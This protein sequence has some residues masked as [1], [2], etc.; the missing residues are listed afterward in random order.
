MNLKSRVVG[1]DLVSSRSY[2]ESTKRAGTRPA[3]TH[4]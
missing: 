4:R 3:P 1:E 2:I